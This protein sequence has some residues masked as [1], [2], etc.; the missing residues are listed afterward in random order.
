M[1]RSQ[2]GAKDPIQIGEFAIL[3]TTC[4]CVLSALVNV[5]HPELNAELAGT[6]STLHLPSKY[7][8]VGAPPV[9]QFK[10]DEVGPLADF[11]FAVRLAR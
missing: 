2:S 10:K 9:L 6:L 1:S 11:L 8:V 7:G 3:H 4:T 5:Y